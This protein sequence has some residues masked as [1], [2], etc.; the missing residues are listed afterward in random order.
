MEPPASRVV[1]IIT[2]CMSGC[3]RKKTL[4][5]H[6]MTQAFKQPRFPT[7]PSAINHF[8][9]NPLSRAVRWSLMRGRSPWRVRRTVVKNAWVTHWELRGFCI[10]G[11]FRL[12]YSGSYVLAG[13]AFPSF[14]TRVP[15]LPGLLYRILFVALIIAV[16]STRL[17]SQSLLFP[18]ETGRSLV[19]NILIFK[20]YTRCQALFTDNPYPAVEGPFSP[21]L[22]A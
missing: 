6:L 3:G 18:P 10:L 21:T 7:S 13:S 22:C 11:L 16:F 5:T 14:G 4:K 12:F 1:A 20:Q 2:V 8:N 9:L 15:L 19:Q 17:T